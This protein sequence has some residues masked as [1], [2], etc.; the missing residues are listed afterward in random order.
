M[1]KCQAC[2]APLKGD[3]RFCGNCG[4]QVEQLLVSATDTPPQHSSESGNPGGLTQCPGCGK[5]ERILLTGK[6]GRF[7]C[8]CGT[9]FATCKHCGKAVELWS[10]ACGDCLRFETMNLFGADSASVRPGQASQTH[11]VDTTRPTQTTITKFVLACP[12]C[13]RGI[14]LPASTYGLT[15]CTCGFKARFRTQAKVGIITE[16]EKWIPPEGSKENLLLREEVSLETAQVNADRSISVD[17][18]GCGTTTVVC[19]PGYP[20]NQGT[21][22]TCQSCNCRFYFSLAQSPHGTSSARPFEGGVPLRPFTPLPLTRERII[23][24]SQCSRKI[25]PFEVSA[26]ATFQNHDAPVGY[27]S[28]VLPTVGEVWTI[29]SRCAESRAVD[30]RKKASQSKADSIRGGISAV[31]GIV[32]ILFGVAQLPFFPFG[33]FTGVLCIIWGISLMK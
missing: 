17:C 15:E 5:K 3:E 19:A 11:R 9:E 27:D 10:D 28:R 23:Y 29:C 1:P 32:V 14:G 7:E 31:W 25:I 2:Q 8:S 6:P 26:G 24:C 22:G 20:T 13:N 30:D 21:W 16:Q 12:K 18:P 33:T 4:H